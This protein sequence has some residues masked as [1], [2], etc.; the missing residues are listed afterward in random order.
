MKCDAPHLFNFDH[1]SG[2]EQREKFEL[3]VQ[4]SYHFVMLWA[5]G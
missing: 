2:R 4:K 1:K 5:L 3:L